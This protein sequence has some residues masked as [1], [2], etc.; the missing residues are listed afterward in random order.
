MSKDE[1]KYEEAET[2]REAEDRITEYLKKSDNRNKIRQSTDEPTGKI[3][4]T[5]GMFEE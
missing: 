3:N 5:A 4:R 1:P 2:N